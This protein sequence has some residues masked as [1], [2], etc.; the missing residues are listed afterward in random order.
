MK[1]N[2]ILLRFKWVQW[3]ILTEQSTITT[4]EVLRPSQTPGPRRG[5]HSGPRCS[6]AR[7]LWDNT[8]SVT[9]TLISFDLLDKFQGH[10]IDFT[11]QSQFTGNG[12]NCTSCE[13][14]FFWGSGGKSL[15]SEEINHLDGGG[16]SRFITDSMQCKPGELSLKDVGIYQRRL[17][18]VRT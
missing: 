2:Q 4:T 5:T 16:D 18:L 9:H 14:S 11:R 1:L 13:N 17:L 3:C 6:P 7:C 10:C 8:G 15:A 12:E